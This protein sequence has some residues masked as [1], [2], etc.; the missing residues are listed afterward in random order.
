[1]DFG[2]YDIDFIAAPPRYLFGYLLGWSW[3][4]YLFVES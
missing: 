2:V 1:M 4:Q 3:R